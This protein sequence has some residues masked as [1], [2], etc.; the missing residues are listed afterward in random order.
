MKKYL[1]LVLLLLTGPALFAQ[2]LGGSLMLG[3]PQGDFRANV[4]RMGFGLQLH[5]TFW[6]PSKERPFTVGFDAGYL[7]YGMTDQRKEW[8]DFPGIYLKLNRTNSV[9]NLHLMLQVSPFYG[10]VRPYVEGLFGGAYIWTS[11]EVKNEN[12]DHPIASSTNYDD[13]TWNY[14]GGAG[15]LFK[16]T[17]N[18][19]KI[20]ALYLDIKAR[21]LFGT[22]ASY[23]TEESVFVN[24]RGDT[25][26]QA[27]KSTTDFFT[28]HVGVVAYFDL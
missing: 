28:F 19:E 17:D 25:I 14:G 4:D 3:Y 10:D 7:V 22:E 11:S 5:G 9:A 24:S 27:R 21:Y 20:S 15:I 26:F 18:L 1:L 23:L 16:L 8:S 2:T 12:G 13:F 6:S